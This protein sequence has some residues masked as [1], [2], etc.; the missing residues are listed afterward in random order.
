MKKKKRGYSE[1]HGLCRL[2]LVKISEGIFVYYV[3]FQWQS[4]LKKLSSQQ[5][6]PFCSTPTEVPCRP[7]CANDTYH[8]TEL[9]LGHV[10]DVDV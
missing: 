9:D 8:G 10:N 6:P 7:W 5:L 2:Y 4:Q 1:R 3:I